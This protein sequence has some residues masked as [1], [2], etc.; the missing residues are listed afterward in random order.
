VRI[1]VLDK[2]WRFLRVPGTELRGKYGDCDSPNAKRR[3]IR[4]WD[5]LTG[6]RELETIIHE[7][8]HAGDWHRD[9]ASVQQFAAD[10]ARILWRLGYRRGT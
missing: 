4:V 6:E 2:L 9:E 5:K 10:A 7:L 8:I 3:T 1:K